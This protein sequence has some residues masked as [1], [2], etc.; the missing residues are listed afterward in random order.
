[1]SQG[2]LAFFFVIIVH[3][4]EDR[5]SKNKKRSYKLPYLFQKSIPKLNAKVLAVSR[6]GSIFGAFTLTALESLLRTFT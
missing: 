4:Q 3:E 2:M 5:V 1:M 6:G